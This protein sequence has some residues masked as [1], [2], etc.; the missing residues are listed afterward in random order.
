[1][2]SCLILLNAQTCKI[3]GRK[4]KINI[5]RRQISF[6]I[7]PGQVFKDLIDSKKI[8]TIQLIDNFRQKDGKQI[9]INA[10]KLLKE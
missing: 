6:P 2:S 8:P 1:M 3:Y 9:V 10:I 5:C 4:Y 7:S